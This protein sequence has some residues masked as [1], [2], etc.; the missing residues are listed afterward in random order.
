VTLAYAAP[1][2]APEP[3]EVLIR[4]GHTKA[5]LS[6]FMEHSQL[7]DF[8]DRL[9]VQAD[10]G[11]RARIRREGMLPWLYAVIPGVAIGATHAIVGVGPRVGEWPLIPGHMGFHNWE[12][13]THVR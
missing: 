9:V 8:I 3:W 1:L 4:A 2:V 10:Q 5:A 13:V 12:S 11:E 6:L 7:D